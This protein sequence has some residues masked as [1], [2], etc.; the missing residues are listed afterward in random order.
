MQRAV[1]ERVLRRLHSAQGT[2]YAGGDPDRVREVLTGGVEWHV[3]G[4]NAIAGD[5]YGI[6]AVLGYFLRRRDLATGTF[7]MQPG[8][9][10]VGD[11]NHA[12]VLTDG[13]AVIAGAERRWSTLGL[14]Q[15]D[16]ERVAACW[17]LPLHPEEF[18]TIWS[19]T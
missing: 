19:G 2:L 1:A 16:E 12:S 7:R 6:E 15:I 5:Y 9:L 10:M 4:S 14:Y 3:P 18:D 13:T 11:G 8:E 17:L